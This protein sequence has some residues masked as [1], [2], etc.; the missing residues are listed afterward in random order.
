MPDENLTIK[1]NFIINEYTIYFIVDVET[2][3]Q[4][5][6]DFDEVINAYIPEKP[7]YAFMGW[8]EAIDLPIPFTTTIKPL[9]KKD[10]VA[11]C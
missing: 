6:F 7:G 4:I 9:A 10:G 11:I 8:F 5:S 1:A 2:V 3:A